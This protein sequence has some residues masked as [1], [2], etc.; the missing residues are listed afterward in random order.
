MF[1]PTDDQIE[2]ELDRLNNITYEIVFKY[3]KVIQDRIENVRKLITKNEL[4]DLYDKFNSVVNNFNN[5]CNQ[6][7]STPQS[8]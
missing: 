2:F 5:L 3:F 6:A 7:N 8:Y 1:K 4:F